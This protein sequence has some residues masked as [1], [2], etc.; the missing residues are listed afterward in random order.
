M[1]HDKART[2]ALV[3]SALALAAVLA[4][5]AAQAQDVT[6]EPIHVI[7]LS[8]VDR[9]GKLSPAVVE[10]ATAAVALALEDVGAYTVASTTDLKRELD[11]M[12]LKP[13]LTTAQQLRLAERLGADKVVTPIVHRLAVDE[14]S[15]AGVCSIEVQALDRVAED[16]TMGGTGSAE[17]PPVPGWDGD[18]SSVINELLRQAAEQAVRDMERRR[19]PRGAVEMIDD[20]GGVHIN[21]GRRDG[22]EVGHEL[23]VMR[24]FYRRELD[25]VIMRK[26][27]TLVVDEVG[28]Q[29]A[30]ARVASGMTPR[31]G[32]RVYV[33][34]RPVAVEKAI[35]ERRKIT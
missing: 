30:V 16:I 19:V 13:P 4:N 26:I 25:K 10:K 34:Y 20:L 21:L 14:K 28:T 29:R 6:K 1:Q 8:A 31:T 23:V 12:G 11:A 5:P 33:V 7:V 2:M 32:D 17:R 3:L 22:L 27:G 18:T 35:K 15:G 9:T 24:G